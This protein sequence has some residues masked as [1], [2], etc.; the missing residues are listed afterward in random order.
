[1]E[2][3]SSPLTVTREFRTVAARPSLPAKS[4][5]EKMASGERKDAPLNADSPF[6]ETSLALLKR[7]PLFGGLEDTVLR[8]MLRIARREI[9]PKKR[10][11]NISRSC[12]RFHVLLSGR[13][14]LFETNPET[15]RSVTL[16][17]LET[18]DAFDIFTLL[19]GK[20]SD[21]FAEAIDD[22]AILSAPVEE[23]R[24]WIG[25]H[26][27]FNRA[28]LPYLGHGMRS[29]ADLAAD[30]ALQTT[31]HR[32]AKLILRHVD[33]EDPSHH[34]RLIN[35]LSDEEIAEMIGTVRAVVNRQLQHW[36]K[37]DVLAS[38]QTQANVSKLEELVRLSNHHLDK[39][40]RES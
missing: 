11:W 6:F 1:M 12:E 18:G 36:K 34:I 27:E 28:L 38:R 33:E 3:Y 17:L 9:V 32:L 39:A 14:K 30:L 2:E 25:R 8:E 29:L 10:S 20:P 35:D 40:R 16:F 37:D 19:D 24:A 31:E 21:L 4:R 15:G 23:V 5:F 7:S 13:L 22:V 26:P